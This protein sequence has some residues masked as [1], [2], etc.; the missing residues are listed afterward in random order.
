MA[1]IAPRRLVIV[2]HPSG[3]YI[4]L[5]RDSAWVT[6]NVAKEAFKALGVE[7]HITYQGASGDHCDP[8]SRTPYL[9]PVNAM[10]DK[11]L[12]DDASAR[13]GTLNTDLGNQ[14]DASERD[15]WTAPTL[16]SEV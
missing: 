1:L 11:I 12:Q 10:I 5:D 9:A 4:G 15:T 16:S 14:P 13:I 8:H 6:A 2:D 7:D 3:T